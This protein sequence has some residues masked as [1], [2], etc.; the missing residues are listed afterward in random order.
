MSGSL[1]AD[2]RW[3]VE[4]EAGLAWREW[5]DEYVVYSGRAAATH[6]LSAFAGALL[7]TL[8]NCPEPQDPAALLQM[9]CLDSG[10][11]FES[12]DATPLEE[13][14]RETLLE[15]ERMGLASRTRT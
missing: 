3:S 5:G 14:I 7:V 11:G 6:L 2:L 10:I 1:A 15:F 13:S 4:P 9:A 8:Q 12:T